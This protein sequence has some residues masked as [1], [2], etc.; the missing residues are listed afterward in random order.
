MLEIVVYSVVTI[1]II[2]SFVLLVTTTVTSGESSIQSFM[3]LVKPDVE[4]FKLKFFGASE[5]SIDNFDYHFLTH[6]VNQQFTVDDGLVIFNMKFHLGLAFPENYHIL[7]ILTELV[8]C[9]H[10][11]IHHPTN[12]GAVTIEFYTIARQFIDEYSEIEIMIDNKTR[13]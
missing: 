10:N 5:L 7:N 1:A 11:M 12:S 4:A 2:T 8:S 6:S 13:K 3:W 9:F